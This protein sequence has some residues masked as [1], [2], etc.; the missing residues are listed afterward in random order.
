MSHSSSVVAFLSLLGVAGAVS[1]NATEPESSTV[2]APAVDARTHVDFPG[3]LQVGGDAQ[4]R[5]VYTIEGPIKFGGNAHQKDTWSAN[6]A[7]K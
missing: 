6:D 1:C 2:Q 4:V 7:P 5:E 3:G